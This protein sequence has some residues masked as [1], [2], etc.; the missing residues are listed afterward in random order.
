MQQ[1]LERLGTLDVLLESGK[2]TGALVCEA[3][4]IDYPHEAKSFRVDPEE[5]VRAAVYV[6]L[7]ARY[8]DARILV[9]VNGHDLRCSDIGLDMLVECKAAY[10]EESLV[11]LRSYLADERLD[12]GYLAFGTSDGGVVLKLVERSYATLDTAPEPHKPVV[13]SFINLKGG[14]GKT[15]LLIAIGEI[16]AYEHRKRCLVIDL[17]P[18]TNATTMLIHQSTWERKNEAGETLYQLFADRVNG[19]R[20]FDLQR[21]IVPRVSNVAGGIEGLDLLPS[22]IGLIEIQDRI[23]GAAG[24]VVASASFL[25]QALSPALSNY[26]VVLIDCP[27][28]LNVVTF[29]GFWISDFCLIPVI[30]DY[31]STWGLPQVLTQI[32]RF[33]RDTGKTLRPLG[34]VINMCR[35]TNLHGAISR[36]LRNGEMKGIA[37]E[38]VFG[39]EVPLT[40]KAELSAPLNPNDDESWNQFGTLH[41][42]YGYGSPQLYAIY[43]EITNELVHRCNKLKGKEVL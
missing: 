36:R 27:P 4:R 23:A 2:Q 31:L 9:E 11:Q 1:G 10:S 28:S 29:N 22:S 34:I 15:T 41:Q 14:V 8:P 39:H 40:V 19:T 5:R 26:D 32:D 37:P 24:P 7:R 6:W 13:I 33:N 17:D 12:R 35:P 3:E 42:K 16:L 25:N 18:Q 20:L 21:V 38:L 43:K 30:P